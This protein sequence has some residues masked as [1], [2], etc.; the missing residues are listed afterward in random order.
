V[1]IVEDK[2]GKRTRFKIANERLEAALLRLEK[3]MAKKVENKNS[4]DLEQIAALIAENNKL[5]DINKT[6]E[7]RLSG[8]IKNL[9]NIL[10][11]A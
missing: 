4:A 11:E 5:K 2:Q 9:E 1:A 7:E 8:T 3:A 10:K 6:A